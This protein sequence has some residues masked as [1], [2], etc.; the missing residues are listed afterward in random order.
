[1]VTAKTEEWIKILCREHSVSWL[2]PRASGITCEAGPHELSRDFPYGEH[3]AY[4]CDC[5]SLLGKQ[6][7][8]ILEV[9]DNRGGRV[10]QQTSV[11]IT[12]PPPATPSPP[13]TAAPAARPSPTAEKKAPPATPDGPVKQLGRGVK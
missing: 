8:V 7:L 13:P 3:W 6:V 9:R 10:E 4:C 11:T 2:A 1:M 5:Q 12:P